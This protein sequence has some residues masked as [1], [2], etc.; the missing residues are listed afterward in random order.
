MIR[1]SMQSN[2]VSLLLA[3]FDCDKW[4]MRR[5]F[6][7]S[8]ITTIGLLRII[9]SD[10]GV[11]YHYIFATLDFGVLYIRA[12]TQI[13]KRNHKIDAGIKS[14]MEFIIEK[15]HSNRCECYF[16][17][18]SYRQQYNFGEGHWILNLTYFQLETLILSKKWGLH[19]W[20]RW[21]IF[22]LSSSKQI[23]YPLEIQRFKK[24]QMK[25]TD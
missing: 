15:K 23:I 20:I 6:F 17:Q 10:F 21:C 14:A 11:S 13:I 12:L 18:S 25:Y 5:S 7:F 16:N 24:N 22:L 4:Y 3:Q 8:L 2:Q 19:L 9:P 1:K